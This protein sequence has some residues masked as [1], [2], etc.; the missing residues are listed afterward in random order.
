MVAIILE[1][2][3]I[4]VMYIAAA[5]HVQCKGLRYTLEGGYISVSKPQGS[6]NN[7]FTIGV[8]TKRYNG[9]LIMA[10]PT[11]SILA[12]LMPCLLGQS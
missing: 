12:S 8:P 5:T 2:N 10:T 7:S 6:Y 1:L 3:S 11:N 4:M 9:I